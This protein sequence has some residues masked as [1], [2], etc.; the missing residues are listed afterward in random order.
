[1]RSDSRKVPVVVLAGHLGAGKTTLLNH[2]LTRPG[3]QVGVVVNDFGDIAV[4][5]GLVTG[6]IDEPAAIS[7]GCLCCLPD[8]GGLDDALE[9]LT[10]PR[11][12]LDAVIVEASGIADPVTLARLVRFSGVERVRPGGVVDVVDAVEHFDTVDTGADPPVRHGAAGL[13]AVNKLDL[14]APDEREARF[15]RVRD[16]VLRRN[17]RAHVVATDHGRIDPDLVYDAAQDVDPPDQLPLAA[18]LRG[19]RTQDH[20]HA[21]AVSVPAHGPV[22]ASRLVD[23]LELPPAGGVYRI[24]GRVAVRTTR[25]V[26]TYLVNVVGRSVHVATSVPSPGVE[27]L[28]AI[29]MHLDVAAVRERVTDALATSDVPDARGFSRLQRHRRLSR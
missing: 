8:A 9:V 11:R 10:A 25:D 17:P 29:G 16:R 7:G 27:G 18:L 4:D 5:A 19:S 13:V 1:M 15:T 3:A 14:L 26:R 20:V 23:L 24:K 22:S 2:L 21:D 28:V 6:Q 12:G